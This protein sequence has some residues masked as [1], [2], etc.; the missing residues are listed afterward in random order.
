VTASFVCPVCGRES[1]NPNDVREG[2]CGACHGYTRDAL[3]AGARRR[4][5]RD[6]LEGLRSAL[7]YLEA[8]PDGELDAATRALRDNTRAMLDRY[9]RDAYDELVSP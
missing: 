7:A 8:A 9:D 4:L 6:A 1:W 2:W 5:F 3:P